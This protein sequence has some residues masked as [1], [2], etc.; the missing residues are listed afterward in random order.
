M[1]LRTLPHDR[2]SPPAPRPVRRQRTA[3]ELAPY[4]LWAVTMLIIA[5]GVAR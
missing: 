1:H 5:I 2:P 4:A 3:M